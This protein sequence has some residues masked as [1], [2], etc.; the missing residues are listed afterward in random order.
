MFKD[1]YIWDNHHLS[2]SDFLT[3]SDNVELLRFENLEQ[4][5]KKLTGFELTKHE[6]K[7]EKV[8]TLNDLTSE[9]KSRIYHSWEKDF[10]NYGYER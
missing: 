4:G 8:I 7:R 6:M 5:F 3:G 10:I 1:D 2:C 9:I